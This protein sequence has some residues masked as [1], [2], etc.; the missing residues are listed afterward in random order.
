MRS[1]S[2]NQSWWISSKNLVPRNR[3][4]ASQKRRRI[5]LLLFKSILPV[6]DMTLRRTSL[7]RLQRRITSQDGYLSLLSTY[8]VLECSSCAIDTTVLQ[9]SWTCSGSFSH[10][11]SLIRPHSCWRLLDT[12][13]YSPGNSCSSTAT[14]SLSSRILICAEKLEDTL[15]SAWQI[16]SLSKLA[17]SFC[18]VCSISSWVFTTRYSKLTEKTPCFSSLMKG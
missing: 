3:R 13:L 10:S 8:L 1:L 15:H 16:P 2:R 11:S 18:F 12:S 17:C 5:R 6:K 4:K 9:A 7:R 14:I